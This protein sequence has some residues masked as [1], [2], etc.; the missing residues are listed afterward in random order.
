MFI[1]RQLFDQQSSTYTYLL[2]DGESGEAILIDPVFE[3]ARRDKALI[4]EL[5]L[6]LFATL[7]THV[8]ADHVT[9]ASLLRQSLGN[10]IA[11]AEASGAEGADLYLKH[12]D[13][14]QYGCRYVEARATPGHT[15]GCMTYVLDNEK[16]AFT[17]DTLLI[18]GCGRTDF[19]QGSAR[20]MYQSVHAQIFT[21][22]DECLLYPAHDY[23]GRTVTSVGE[24]EH[25]N[26]RLGG[27]LSESD[28][29]GY[30]SNLNLPHPK[31][32]D[33]AVPANLK[34][35][36]SEDT[37][38]LAEP[39]WAPVAFTFA[40]VWE[41]QPDWLEEH[42]GKVQVLDVREAEEFNG[43]LGHIEDAILVPLGE[44]S[45][46]IG[47]LDKTRPVIAVCRAGGRSAHATMVLQKAGFDKVANLAGGMLRWRAEG[48][49]VK[50]GAD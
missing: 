21:L 35:G 36:A 6:T 40:G 47:E 19:Q 41:I 20:N 30:M 49:A 3:Q 46:Q 26:P 34:C 14:V 13:R 37:Q 4:T 28:F 8:H 16:M 32:I 38:P 22:P 2:G 48:H 31:Q 7:D 25:L 23:Q 27:A 24:E 12:G 10:K 15:S 43:P 42:P 11:V 45:Q 33:I 1:F 44:L 50:G 18:R 5:G 17:G 39:D 29:A 9:G